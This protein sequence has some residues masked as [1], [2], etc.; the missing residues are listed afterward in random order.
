[1]INVRF[2]RLGLLAAVVATALSL[3]QTDQSPLK[4]ESPAD[5]SVVN[6]G[7]TVKIRVVSA[8]SAAIS[9]VGVVGENPL[10]VSELVKSVPA[11]FSITIP[12]KIDACRRYMV[13]AMG[14]T[15]GG[16]E[17]LE[18]KI[19]LD[20]ERPDTPVSIVS[21]QFPSLTLVAD[22]KAQP[23]HLII[24]AT[25]A[26]QSNVEVTESSYVTYQS[27]NK[28]VATVEGFGGVT[29]VA[30]GI[31]SIKVTYKNPNGGSVQVSVPVIV[32]PP[33]KN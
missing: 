29:A 27:T 18:S 8:T 9:F 14:R 6:P 32:E 28:A 17:L 15:P 22:P 21:F 33:S 16:A 30:P 5:G 13:T 11:E 3:A 2:P 24:L 1:M 31:A 20:V 4:I 7:Q 10:G 12:L 23:F 26:D 19:D 25:F